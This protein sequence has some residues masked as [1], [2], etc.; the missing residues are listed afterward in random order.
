MDFLWPVGSTLPVDIVEWQKCG[1]QYHGILFSFND[2]KIFAS[3]FQLP[4][5]SQPL[6]YVISTLLLVGLSVISDDQYCPKIIA[7]LRVVHTLTK[8][9]CN[10]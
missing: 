6:G 7:V 2:V 3:N 4:K 5:K 1:P 8:F 10:N 9:N